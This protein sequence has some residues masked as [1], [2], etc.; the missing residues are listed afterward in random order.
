MYIHKLGVGSWSSGI[1]AKGRV[2][3]LGERKIKSKST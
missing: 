2:Q 3:A 1:R